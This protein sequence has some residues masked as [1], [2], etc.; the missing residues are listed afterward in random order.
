MCVLC[1][2]QFVPFSNLVLGYICSD[3]TKST[4][5]FLD[6]TQNNLGIS[7]EIQDKKY[8]RALQGTETKSS[9]TKAIQTTPKPT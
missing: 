1:F 8:S 3:E 4:H 6:K 5:N 2:K 7:Q 9:Q